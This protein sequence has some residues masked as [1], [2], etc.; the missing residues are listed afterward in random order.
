VLLVPTAGWQ[1]NSFS[2]NKTGQASEF[3]CW[4]AFQILFVFK[5]SFVNPCLLKN[6]VR[7]LNDFNDVLSRKRKLGEKIK[8]ACIICCKFANRN[9]H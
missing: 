6:C 1:I 3:D 7:S 9:A 5:G 4:Q 2:R 8:V